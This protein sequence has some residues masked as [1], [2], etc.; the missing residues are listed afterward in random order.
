[1]SIMPVKRINITLHNDVYKTL[2]DIKDEEHRNVSNCISHMIITY[3]SCREC[4]L[5]HNLKEFREK[6]IEVI[7]KVL[8]G[9]IDSKE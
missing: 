7:R 1:M 6:R 4:P 2:L 9:E 3:N 5:H 8:E